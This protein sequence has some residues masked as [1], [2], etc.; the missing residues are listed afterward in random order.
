MK[1]RRREDKRGRRGG[2]G[3]NENQTLEAFV[4][5]S[6][7]YAKC[8]CPVNISFLATAHEC[9]IGLFDHSLSMVNLHGNR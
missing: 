4:A 2:G 5:A 3:E 9:E 6:R 1:G 7:L 8:D